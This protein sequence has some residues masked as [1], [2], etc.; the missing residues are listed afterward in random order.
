[1]RLGKGVPLKEKDLQHLRGSL[2]TLIEEAD[3]ILERLEQDK[4]LYLRPFGGTEIGPEARIPRS[5]LFTETRAVCGYL[6]RVR[7]RVDFLRDIL[8]IAQSTHTHLEQLPLAEWCRYKDGRYREQGPPWQQ[9]ESDIGDI[10]VMLTTI[11]DQT[12]RQRTETPAAVEQPFLLKP[13]PEP[14][15]EDHEKLAAIVEPYGVA[16]KEDQNLWK[17]CQQADSVKVFV[18]KNWKRVTTWK[19]GYKK[20]KDK[21]IKVIQSRLKKIGPSPETLHNSCTIPGN[22]WNRFPE[23]FFSRISSNLQTFL[24]QQLPSN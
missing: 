14:K 23:T 15:T 2:V 4:I 16:W 5:V 1:M 9:T 24:V 3:R 8:P 13:G 22:S 21:L 12:S 7:Q 17:I 11:L 6:S 18:P 19:G 10:R 20:H